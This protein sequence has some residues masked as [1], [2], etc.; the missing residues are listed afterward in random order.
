MRYMILKIFLLGLMLF[1]SKVSTLGQNTDIR[2]EVGG[3][4]LN[5]SQDE[6]GYGI[7]FGSFS[8]FEKKDARGRI[9]KFY[10]LP[11]TKLTLS[12]LVFYAPENKISSAPQLI[13]TMILGKR[14]V[15]VSS[16]SE[17]NKFFDE[18]TKHAVIEVSAGYPM[19]AFDEKSLAGLSMSF[20]GKK[21]PIQI[22]MQCK[23][24]SE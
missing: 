2:C 13:A 24:A 22:F 20:L 19:K 11:R 5:L 9:T 17:H 10:K 1:A 21:K 18:I 8:L 7:K 3:L 6:P 16:D 12:I 14:K 23:K 4:D 15:P